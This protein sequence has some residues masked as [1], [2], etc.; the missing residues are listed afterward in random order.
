MSYTCIQCHTN[1]LCIPVLRMFKASPGLY[2][3]ANLGSSSVEPRGGTA[4]MQPGTGHQDISNADCAKLGLYTVR[5]DWLNLGE[6][7][8]LNFSFKQTVWYSPV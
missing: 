5:E 8:V 4:A 7:C 1:I 3:Y 6:R 2:H